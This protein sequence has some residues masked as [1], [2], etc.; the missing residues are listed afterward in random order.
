MTL[1]R[2]DYWSVDGTTPRGGSTARG[3][4]LTDMEEYLLAMDAVRSAGLYGW[5]VADGLS[6][7]AQS[8]QP[9]VTISPGLALDVFGRSIALVAGGVAVVD[10]TLPPDQKQNVPTV[11]VTP[12]GVRLDSAGLAGDRLL[13]LAWREVIDTGQVPGS[14]VLL[15]SPWLQ[16]ADPATF[17]YGGA[18]VALARVSL[19]TT[20]A[21]TALDAGPRQLVSVPAGRL[22]LRYPR[23]S[24]SGALSVSQGPGAE[25]RARAGGGLDISRLIPGQTSRPALSVDGGSG[26]LLLAPSG[27]QVGIGTAQPARTLH[28]E[29]GLHSGGASAGLSFGSTDAGTFVETPDAGQRWVWYAAAGVARLWSGTDQLTIG[30]PGEGGGLDVGRCMRV[31]QGSHDASAGIWFRQADPDAD[32]AFVGMQDNDNVGLYGSGGAGWSL[33]MNVNS[34]Q[35]STTGGLG[36]GAGTRADLRVSGD[37]VVGAGSNGTLTL[38][39]I[40]GKN[41]ASDDPD[42]L[43]LNWATGRGVHVGGA[44]A[45]PL[46]VHGELH[47]DAGLFSG[48]VTLPAFGDISAPGRLHISGD[49][50]LFLLN[51]S[52]VIVSGAWGG[53]GTLKTDG[54][55]GTYGRDPIIGLPSG[56]GG[57]V[58]TWDVYAEA[59]VGCGPPGISGD[60]IPAG[61]NSSGEMWGKRKSFVIDHPLDPASRWLTHACVEGPEAGVYYRGTGQLADGKARVT[62][63]DYFEALAR[64]E[65]R[66]VQLT[67]VSDAD[68]P[69]TVLAAGTVADGGFDVRAADGRNPSQRFC[70]EVKAVRADLAILQV[71]TEKGMTRQGG[72]G[73]AGTDAVPAARAEAGIRAR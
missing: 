26:N 60:A 5:G 46:N 29:G 57:G 65:D 24:P 50:I 19:D 12:D 36:V 59:T 68:E 73:H 37:A 54:Q 49:E 31:R 4:S 6:V 30:A 2:T 15:H 10:Q 18:A 9:G 69:I 40:N 28:V 20:G 52:G 7:T 71:E 63:P 44:V 42:D 39:H 53:N 3:E 51:K 1:Q 34:G 48:G 45:A 11:L 25:L 72:D 17:D 38:R 13:A 41:Y 67:P 27:E 55:I 14:P 47:V 56:W 62:L 21:V 61:L 66:T 70:W 32:R 35:L 33:L 64:A 43:Y 58:H 16:W 8:G 22:E 23:S